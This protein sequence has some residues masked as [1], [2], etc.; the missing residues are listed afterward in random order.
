MINNAVI[1]K[2]LPPKQCFYSIIQFC[3]NKHRQEAVNIAVVVEAP[4]Y[5]FRGAKYLRHMDSLLKSLDPFADIDLIRGYVK[6]LETNFRRSEVQINPE[7][8]TGAL[9]EEINKPVGLDELI[10]TLR[11]SGRL[12]LTITDRRPTF[13]PIENPTSWKL[14]SL[15]NSLIYRPREQSRENFDK[16][17]VRRT[18]VNIL[19]RYINIDLDIEPITGARYRDNEFDAGQ[20][21]INGEVFNFLEFLTYD[22]K[23]PDTSQM[24]FFL[25][26]VEDVRKSGKEEKNGYYFHAIVQPPKNN[27]EKENNRAFDLALEYADKRQVPVTLLE[28]NEIMRLGKELQPLGR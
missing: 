17:Y 1:Q 24:R 16:D 14:D 4:E 25:D 21:N 20:K 22:V 23:S 18:S 7:L 27:K 15:Y 10:D 8:Y 11:Y 2:P 28:T 3:P 6:G 19:E 9:L 5:G 12:P 13:F 26:T